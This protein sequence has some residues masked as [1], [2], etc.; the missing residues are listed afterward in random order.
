MKKADPVLR[1][2]C[3]ITTRH[4]GPSP[5][6]SS[7]GALQRWAEHHGITLRHA[8]PGNSQQ[9]AYVER[10]NRSVRYDWLAIKIDIREFR[11]CHYTQ[12]SASVLER[13]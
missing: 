10:Y 11:A 6:A 4:K 8:Q 9:N 5:Y 1:R 2:C 3:Q 7:A 12:L 13:A